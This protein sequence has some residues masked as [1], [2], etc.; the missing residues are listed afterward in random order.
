MEWR[1][2]GAEGRGNWGITNE[3]AIKS[4]LRKVSR[5]DVHLVS[6]VNNNVL[7]TLKVV[8]MVTTTL[9]LM[10]TVPPQ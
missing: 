5:A 9:Q 6:I 4:H 2:S 3:W 7:Y 10:L 8:E 1:L